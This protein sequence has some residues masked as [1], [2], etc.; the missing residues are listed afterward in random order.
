MSSEEASKE[1]RDSRQ[2]KARKRA[3]Q[4]KRVMQTGPRA[5]ERAWHRVA[6]A[7]QEQAESNL[8]LTTA[9]GNGDGAG[10]R[11]GERNRVRLESPEDGRPGGQPHAAKSCG[12]N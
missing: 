9:S 6:Q 11:A 12:K 7:G 10:N 8:R 3:S 1:V 2:A 5:G 4:V